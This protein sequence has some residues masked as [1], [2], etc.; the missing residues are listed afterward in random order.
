MESKH[1]KDHELKCKHCGENHM[2]KEFLDRLEDIRRAYGK[3]ISVSSGYRCPS[4]NARISR[5]G[6]SGP[7]TTGSAIDIAISGKDAYLLVRLAMIHGMTGIGI[8]QKGNW[9]KRF[10]HIDMCEQDNIPRP[11]VWSY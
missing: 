7:H 4:Y 1:F 2:K 6:L 8:N 10:I 3:P 5:T 11:R 9:D